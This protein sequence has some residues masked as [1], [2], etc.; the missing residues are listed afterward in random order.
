MQSMT[1]LLEGKECTY[2][3]KQG[4]KEFEKFCRTK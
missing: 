4:G 3:S 2:A 1:G